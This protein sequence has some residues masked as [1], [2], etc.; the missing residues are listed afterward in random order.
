M[1]AS[2]LLYLY[3]QGPHAEVPV[4]DLVDALDGPSEDSV[5]TAIADLEVQGL[6]AS[7]G[8]GDYIMCGLTPEGRRLVFAYAEELRRDVAE[9][10]LTEAVPPAEAS[11]LAE[12]ERGAASAA[13]QEPPQV[14][15]AEEPCAADEDGVS[16]YTTGLFDCRETI[17]P[18]P[19]CTPRQVWQKAVSK[20]A[21][22]GNVIGDLSYYGF[23]QRPARW[24]VSIGS[25]SSWIPDD[26]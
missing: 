15:I 16:G 3:Q 23:G 5:R 19:R 18:N 6:V 4:S 9:E 12:T 22:S 21:P 13:I 10:A 17:V 26:C 7:R 2:V 25:F 8:F 20:G 24:N 1:M 14:S 11:G